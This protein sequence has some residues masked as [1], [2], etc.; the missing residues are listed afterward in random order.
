MGALR[1]QL[2]QSNIERDTAKDELAL[3][4]TATANTI[5]PPIEFASVD[6]DCLMV[7]SPSGYNYADKV[8]AKPG[9]R[10]EEFPSLKTP[11][12]KKPDET[13]HGQRTVL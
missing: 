1:E 12:F 13:R 3:L 5:L 7:I 10:R 9:P 4:R 11:R 6:D 8:K 2:R